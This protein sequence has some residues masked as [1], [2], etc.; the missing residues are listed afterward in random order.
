MAEDGRMTAAQAVE[1]V[2]G[3]EHADVIRESVR[4]MVDALMEAEVSAMIGA[5]FG[6]R[7]LRRPAVLVHVADE[8][9][10]AAL[11]RAAEHP[12]DRVLEPLVRV[13]DAHPDGV[14]AAALERSEE[15]APEGL[16]LDFANVEADH[17]APPGLVHR[18]ADHGRFGHH[19]RAGA[20]PFLLGV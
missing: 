2:M 18:V 5:E 6:E 19:V 9:D 14:E 12:R 10:G 7:A 3:S 16:G 1:K 11:P 20:H 15:L 4:F 17:L 13:R 8:V